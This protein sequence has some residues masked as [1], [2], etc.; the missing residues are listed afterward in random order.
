VNSGTPR[1]VTWD[2]ILSQAIFCEPNSGTWTHL[3][4]AF[5]EAPVDEDVVWTDWTETGALATTTTT[6]TTSPTKVAEII[7]CEDD[8]SDAADGH[9]ADR[10]GKR[11]KLAPVAEPVAE[12]VAWSAPPRPA[13]LNI[14]FNP[15]DTK[16]IE[17]SSKIPCAL[18]STPLALGSAKNNRRRRRGRGRQDRRVA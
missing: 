13:Y 17:G 10:D 6:T 11:R 9:D 4:R 8:H 1:S 2:K 7:L 14:I 12:P 5:S 3:R 16:K 15:S 18:C